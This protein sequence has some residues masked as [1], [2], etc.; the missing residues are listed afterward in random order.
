M[1]DVKLKLNVHEA[2]LLRDLIEQMRA[3]LQESDARNPIHARLFP[4]AYEGAEDSANYR[5]MVGRDLAATKL[6]ALE[7]VSENLGDRRGNKTTLS[8]EDAEAWIRALTDM[9]LAIGTRLDVTAETMDVEPDPRD[10]GYEPLR[11]MHWLG[12]L[13]ESILENMVP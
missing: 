9:R 2:A 13:Q 12:W 11:I 5:E 3:L 6:E 8:P 10:P 7:R 4:D 1:T